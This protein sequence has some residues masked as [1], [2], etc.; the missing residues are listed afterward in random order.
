MR[1]TIKLILICLT[2]SISTCVAAQEK[3]KLIFSLDLIRHGDRTPIKKIPNILYDWDLGL[4][5]LTPKGMQQEYDLGVKLRKKYVEEYKLLPEQYHP[6]TLYVR[7]TNFDRTLMSAQSLLLGLYPLGTGSDTL[8]Q[9][10]QPIPI[11]TLSE[12]SDPLLIKLDAK[13]V[14]ALVK[15][16]VYA[17]PE[18]QAKELALKKYYPHWTKASGMKI[19]SLDRVGSLADSLYIYQLNNIPIPIFN[20]DEIKFIIQNGYEVFT[21]KFKEN[22]IGKETAAPTL[23][24]IYNYL[25]DALQNETSLKYVLLSAHDSNILAIMSALD[26]PLN[27]IPP[28]ASYLNFSLFETEKKNYI[29]EI[30]YNDKRVFIPGCIKNKC[31]LTQL[32]SIIPDPN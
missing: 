13:E 12:E 29:V 32:K 1:L 2:I 26:A 10:Y 31:S 3:S 27:E 18:W 21:L 30:S 5:Q 4:G 11:H 8:P 20:Q 23:N 19:A 22:I 28:Y 24:L 7:S 14:Q 25:N 9:K 17:S 16:E 15:K 6:K